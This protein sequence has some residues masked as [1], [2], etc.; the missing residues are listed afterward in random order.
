[1]II[2]AGLGL[3]IGGVIGGVTAFKKEHLMPFNNGTSFNSMEQNYT[4]LIQEPFNDSTVI[5]DISNDKVNLIMQH[6]LEEKDLTKE[7][8]E[9]IK[10]KLN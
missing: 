1:V 4:N 9:H 7:E 8:S 3:F 2:F 6:Q 5:E 10:K